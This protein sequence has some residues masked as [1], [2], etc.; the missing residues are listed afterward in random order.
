MKAR[1]QVAAIVGVVAL[2]FSLAPVAAG[3][4]ESVYHKY[5]MKG[6]IIE[7]SSAGVYLCIGTADGAQVGEV[8]A[9]VH[10]KRVARGG[11]GQAPKF[12]REAVGTIRIDKIVDEHYARATVLTGKVRKHDIV[13]LTEER[14]E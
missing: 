10:V 13:E 6:A 7:S 11:K 14:S 1:K 9:V 4:E 3:A 12:E 5:V 2:L 8:L